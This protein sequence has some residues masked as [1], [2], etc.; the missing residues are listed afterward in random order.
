MMTVFALLPALVLG[1]WL[2]AVPG[3]PTACSAPDGTQT[4]LFWRN[5][6]G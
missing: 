3:L 2:T 6:F 1:S 4:T 5:C